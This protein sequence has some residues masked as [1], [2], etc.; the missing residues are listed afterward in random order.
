MKIGFIT[1]EVFP[2]AKVGGLG[3][4]S[5]ALPLALKSLKNIARRRPQQH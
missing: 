5:S 2:Y 1:T 3:D 4:V